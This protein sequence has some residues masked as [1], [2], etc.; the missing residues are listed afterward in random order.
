MQAGTKLEDMKFDMSAAAPVLGTF[1][2]L[3][4]VQLSRS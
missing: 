1:E 2:T 3:L 4:C